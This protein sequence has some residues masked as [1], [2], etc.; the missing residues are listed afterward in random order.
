MSR[1]VEKGSRDE[2]A[3]VDDI[4]RKNDL[5]SSHI[6][7]EWKGKNGIVNGF[8]GKPDKILV[9]NSLSGKGIENDFL[10]SGL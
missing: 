5:L 10:E 3:V 8:G 4:D 1:N 7:G 9:R 2:I 6:H